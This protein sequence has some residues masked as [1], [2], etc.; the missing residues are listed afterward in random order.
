MQSIQSYLES[1]PNRLIACGVSFAFLF[2]VFWPLEAAFP[3]RKGQPF[4]RPAWLTDLCFFGGQYLLWNAV[5]LAVLLAFNGWLQM[6]VPEA[7][8]SNFAGLPFWA[9]T[10]IV[11]LLSDFLIYWGHR[12]QH[13]VDFLWRFHAV[14]HSAEHLDWLAAHR[15]HPIDSIYT[16][17]LIN[18]PGFILGYPV[19]GIM[20]FVAFR[21]IW[22]IYIHSNVRLP[23]GPLR[24][25]IGAPELHHWHHDHDRDAGNY[26]NLSP[27][28]DLAFGTYTCPGHEPRAFGIK[29]PIWRSYLGQMIYPFL[30]RR[31]KATCAAMGTS[32]ASAPRSLGDS[33]N[34]DAALHLAPPP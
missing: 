25:F 16:I 3:A 33:H 21:G 10:L 26:A 14:H 29:E 11:L 13:K 2:I 34:L 9:Q 24:A 27:L 17:G 20:G 1:F 32:D 19:A 7:L 5:V 6:I 31:K 23:I 28:M 18:L 12:L 22:A 15:E 30:P 8:R 4:F